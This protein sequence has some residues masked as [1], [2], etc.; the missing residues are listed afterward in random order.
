MRDIIEL[1]ELATWSTRNI[2]EKEDEQVKEM[3]NNNI[4]MMGITKIQKHENNP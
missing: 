3:L 1:R 4:E 2:A